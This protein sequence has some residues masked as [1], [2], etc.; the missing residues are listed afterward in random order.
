MIC[1]PTPTLIGSVHKQWY[2]QFT[3]RVF[4]TTA[5]VDAFGVCL[6]GLGGI[7]VEAR[8]S[9]FLSLEWSKSASFPEPRAG[10]AAGVINGKLVIAGGTYWD[11]IKGHWTKKLYSASTHAFDPVSRRW[12]KLPALPISLGY[13]ASTVVN[14]RL[15]V[16]GGYTGS[17]VNRRIFMLQNVGSRYTW[18]VCGEMSADRNFAS[19]VSVKGLIYLVGGTTS[20]EA[21]DAAG[22]CCT[23]NTVTRSLL[24]FNTDAPAKGWRELA[25]YPGR[26]RWMPAVATDGK[27]IWLFGGLFQSDSNAPVTDF[28]DVLRYDVVRGTWSVVSTLPKTVADAQP[29]SSLRIKDHLFLF[30]S[31]NTVWQLNLHTQRYTETTPMPEAVFVDQFVWLHHRIIGAGGESQTEGPRRRSQWTFNAQIVL[32]K[33]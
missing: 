25:P 11:G 24:V 4:K 13:A 20:F 29:L 12:E 21:L 5:I 27:A 19:A 17:S 28:D 6:L 9:S 8:S 1:K 31:Q 18:S 22:T 7:V 30:T 15:F 33:E 10:Y 32:G 3:A 14:E 23:S 16:L 26:G 2:S